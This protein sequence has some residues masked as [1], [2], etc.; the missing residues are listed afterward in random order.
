MA[1]KKKAIPDKPIVSRVPLPASDSA[2]VIDL[3]DGQKLV[4]GKM[5]QGTV[6]EV[7][8]WR[9]VGRPDSRT[10]R[11]MFGMSSAEIDVDNPDSEVNKSPEIAGSIL[12]Q[13]LG[14]PMALIRWLFNIQ[15]VPKPKKNKDGSKKLL[16]QSNETQAK[17][18]IT[19]ISSTAR[20]IIQRLV[21]KAGPVVAKSYSVSKDKIMMVLKKKSPVK[22]ASQELT[23]TDLDVEKWLE[24]LTSSTNKKSISSGNTTS[25]T[26]KKKK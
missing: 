21:Q 12:S 23:S 1:E 13:I 14:Y 24:S 9:G 22:S 11:M 15:H 3:P 16:V 2:L 7:A 19:E 25:N 4:I 5:G 17:S 6:I 10:S 26:D 8:T 20:K 18:V